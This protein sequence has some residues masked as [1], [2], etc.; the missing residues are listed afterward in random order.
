MAITAKNGKYQ[1]SVY[2]GP[3][4]PRRYR[5][6]KTQR[7]AKDWEA[8][9]RGERDTAHILTVKQF[10]G[11]WLKNYPRLKRS[12]EIHYE[13]SIRGF[14]GVFGHVK[15]RDLSRPKVREWAIEHPS[16]VGTAR[17]ML[18][19][20]FRD[21]LVAANP[22][23]GMR[24][25]GSRGRKDIAALTEQ[26]IDQLVDCATRVHGEYGRVVYGPMILIAAYTGLRPGELHGLRWTDLDENARLLKVERQFSPKA[27]QFTTP[28]N[29]KT[30]TVTLLPPALEAF[31]TMPRDSRSVCVTKNGKHFSG[32]VS[33]YYWSPVRAAF[34][35][36]D[37]DWYAL[38]HS[39]GSML[40][41][42]GVG[43]PEIA[44]AMGHTDGGKLALERYIHISETESQERIQAAYG[45][46][47]LRVVGGAA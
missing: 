39:F 41:R 35:D 30:R 20:A 9:A 38:R 21:G 34:G 31:Q 27:N 12:T 17:A 11:S 37:L 2:Q 42:M 8:Q 22:L 43:A 18:G 4:Q 19:D 15:L 36:P 45:G 47:H 16:Q 10:A 1:A 14:V 40:A 44:R 26:Q 28:K 13:Q 46:R 32:R 23:A 6:F 33:H 7:E 3:G 24:L 25:P 29:G 5:T